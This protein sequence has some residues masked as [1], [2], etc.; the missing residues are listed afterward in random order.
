MTVRRGRTRDVPGTTPLGVST[1][2][3]CAAAAVAG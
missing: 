1:A 3:L 2:R